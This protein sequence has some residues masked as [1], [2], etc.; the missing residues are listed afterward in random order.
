MLAYHNGQETVLAAE[1]AML[2]AEVMD[3][4]SSQTMLTMT[5]VDVLVVVM[6]HVMAEAFMDI[7]MAMAMAVTMTMAVGYY[8]K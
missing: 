6:D 8:C 1:A 2:A 3:N 7:I 4:T 5:L